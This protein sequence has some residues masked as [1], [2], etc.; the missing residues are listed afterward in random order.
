MASEDRRVYLYMYLLVKR[1]TN[2]YI[3]PKHV[4]FLKFCPKIMILRQNRSF[5]K[6]IWLIYSRRYCFLFIIIVYVDQWII[7]IQQLFCIIYFDQ[8]TQA[9][10]MHHSGFLT[11]IQ[12]CIHVLD[13]QNLPTKDSIKKL[14]FV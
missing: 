3:D 5:F 12:R 10:L 6:N 13:Y 7:N 1:A 9:G 2:P 8:A 4:Y 11:L 14:V